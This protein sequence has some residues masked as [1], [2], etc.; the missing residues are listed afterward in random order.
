MLPRMHNQTV[1]DRFITRSRAFPAMRYSNMPGGALLLVKLFN[2]T[3]NEIPDV[4][5]FFSPINHV[6]THCP[7]TLLITGDNDFVVDASHS[8]RL[9]HAL[10][11][12]DVP[13]V[14]VEFPD[15]VHGFDQYFGVSRR[16]APAAQMATNDIEQFLALMG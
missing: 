16:V 13:S 1:L 2:G 3:L 12:L 8:R 11:T 7:P 14:H 10:Q 4:Y 5:Q 6:G 15:T 9:H